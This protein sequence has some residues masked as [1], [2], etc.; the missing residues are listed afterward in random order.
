MINRDSNIILAAAIFIIV[1]LMLVTF[2]MVRSA[3]QTTQMMASLDSSSR[4]LVP[5][6]PLI[7]LASPA[8]IAPQ[9]AL[10]TQELQE[11]SVVPVIKQSEMT[12]VPLTP[13]PW[14]SPT[15]YQEDKAVSD[16]SDTITLMVP[17]GWYASF[18]ETS[19]GTTVIAN[20]DLWALE[21]R[22][23]GGM[24]VELGIGSLEEGQTFDQWLVERRE[25]LKSDP[26]GP[27]PTFITDDQPISV[28]R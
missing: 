16:P 11:E 26:Y 5:I 1:A 28:R 17:K 14:I 8:A 12:P 18:S 3:S 19:Q 10:P 4:G 6:S 24:M 22:P 21:G 15:P 13:E 23:E 20:F 25:H 2:V 7:S 27:G 9:T